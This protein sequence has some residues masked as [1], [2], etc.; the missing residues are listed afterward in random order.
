MNKYMIKTK[1]NFRP[2]IKSINKVSLINRS[3]K[4]TIND[5]EYPNKKKDQKQKK[6]NR[7]EARKIKENRDFTIFYGYKIFTK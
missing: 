1:I 6:K 4:T 3:K 2:C 5:F 7:R